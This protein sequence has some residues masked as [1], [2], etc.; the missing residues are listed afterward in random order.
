MERKDPGL[1]LSQEAALRQAQ[2]RQRKQRGVL[3]R[4][5]T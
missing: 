1:F 5:H 2:G 3:K 4:G